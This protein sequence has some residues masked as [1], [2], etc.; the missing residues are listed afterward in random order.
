MPSRLPRPT[1]FGP[2]DALHAALRRRVPQLAAHKEDR[3]GSVRVSYRDAGPYRVI[4]DAD[5]ATFR[6]GSGPATGTALGRLDTVEDVAD[7]IAWTLGASV[8]GPRT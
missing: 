5:E 8:R 1:P 6:W 7:A 3:T 2:L 4:W